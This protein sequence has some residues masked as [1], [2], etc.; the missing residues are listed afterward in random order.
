MNKKIEDCYNKLTS[1]SFEELEEL[2]G[3][4]HPR[5]LNAMIV[6]GANIMQ[7]HLIHI[8]TCEENDSN[9]KP[10]NNKRSS[11]A[12]KNIDKSNTGQIKKR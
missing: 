11:K 12:T 9:E 6:A 1:L 7:N 3:M 5:A 10:T 4:I 2:L 8:F